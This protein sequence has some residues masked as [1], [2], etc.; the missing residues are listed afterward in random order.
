[1][2]RAGEELEEIPEKFLKV[3]TVTTP[4]LLTFET[5]PPEIQAALL[6][7]I[8]VEPYPMTAQEANKRF[9]S[10]MQQLSKTLQNLRLTSKRTKEIIDDKGVIVGMIN[11]LVRRYIKSFITIAQMLKIPAAQR[12]IMQTKDTITKVFSSLH[13]IDYELSKQYHRDKNVKLDYESVSRSVL[14]TGYSLTSGSFVYPESSGKKDEP[15]IIRVNARGEIDKTYGTQGLALPQ[16][17]IHKNRIHWVDFMKPGPVYY[18]RITFNP[19]Y[20]ITFRIENDDYMYVLNKNGS[21]ISSIG[22]HGLISFI[23]RT[24]ENAYE[25]LL[26]PLWQKVADYVPGDIILSA[27]IKSYKKDKSILNCTVQINVL[28]QTG[29][30]TVLNIVVPLDTKTGNIVMDAFNPALR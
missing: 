13:G 1:M 3:E 19:F 14:L 8:A 4:P 30:V 7:F 21:L 27:R 29:R 2:K 12:L 17:I 15:F 26:M 5:L 24:G 18:T 6:P 23:R 20:I 16:E 11:T 22:H 28:S 9:K 25:S 10:D